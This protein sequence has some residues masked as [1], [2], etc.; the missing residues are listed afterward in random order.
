MLFRSA[1]DVLLIL[2]EVLSVNS[3]SATRPAG[4]YSSLIGALIDSMAKDIRSGSAPGQDQL[5]LFYIEVM[6]LSTRVLKALGMKFNQEAFS[7]LLL[8][9]HLLYGDSGLIKWG[10]PGMVMRIG[11]KSDRGENLIKNPNLANRHESDESVQDTYQDIIGYCVLGTM[12]L[13]RK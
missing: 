12:M 11:S 8:R 9:K 4:Y 1:D 10:H 13:R 3:S 2:D 5:A 6:I 7:D